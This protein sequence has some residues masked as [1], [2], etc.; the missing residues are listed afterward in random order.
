MDAEKE[1]ERAER[2]GPAFLP[3]HLAKKLAQQQASR[4]S[5]LNLPKP[6]LSESDLEA[7][8]KYGHSG[9]LAQAMAAELA[10]PSTRSL[11]GSTTPR[12]LHHLM[13]PS[14]HG[15]STPQSTTSLSS[16][17][18]TPIRDPLGLNPSAQFESLKLTLQQP[19]KLYQPQRTPTNLSFP[20]KY[21][22]YR[23][24]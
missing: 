1:K 7:L 3:A 17:L 19:S 15:N 10:T 21:L 16:R 22:Y 13:T 8:S 14:V 2:V 18:Q 20:T 11:L 6:Q 5:A 12:S 4:R 9:G 23:I 24:N